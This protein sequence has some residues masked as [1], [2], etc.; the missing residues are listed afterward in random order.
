MGTLMVMAM[1]MVMVIVVVV[2][3]MGKWVICVP[4][5]VLWPNLP[6]WCPKEHKHIE[7]SENKAKTIRHEFHSIP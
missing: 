7:N 3:R 2:T 1:A 6:A 5:T 4:G